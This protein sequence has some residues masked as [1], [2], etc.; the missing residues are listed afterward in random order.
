MPLSSTSTTSCDEPIWVVS[1]YTAKVDKHD[2]F[3][4]RV[5]LQI[6]SYPIFLC[7]SI[8]TNVSFVDHV[9]WTGAGRGR[10]R[11]G[12]SIIRITSVH[13]MP[14]WKRQRTGRCICGIT[15]STVKRHS[16]HILVGFLHV[17]VSVYAPPAYGELL[18]DMD[19]DAIVELRYNKALRE[20]NRTDFAPVMNFM[21]IFAQL[22]SS[23]HN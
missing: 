14:R 6:L 2:V 9:D 3:V 22:I 8:V 21:V 20:G 7:I 18:E 4:A 13:S 1:N 17:P 10:S 23:H 15:P 11:N 19:D 5:R 12:I 16:L